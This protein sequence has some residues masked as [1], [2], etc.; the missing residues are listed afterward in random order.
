[1]GCQYA[2]VLSM[3]STE[4]ELPKPAWAALDEPTAFKMAPGTIGHGLL[5]EYH[6]LLAGRLRPVTIF[7]QRPLS[8]RSQGLWKEAEKRGLLTA[9]EVLC[10]PEDELIPPTFSDHFVKGLRGYIE[11][12]TIPPH[13]QLVNAVF[14]QEH[15]FTP[16]PPA[17]EQEFI[18]TVEDQLDT[19]GPRRRDVLVYRYGLADGII[20]SLRQTAI[21]PAFNLTPERIR[22]IEAAALSRLRHPLR[23]RHLKM[24]MPFPEGSL[25]RAVFGPRLRRYL[26]PM[27]DVQLPESI[28]AELLRYEVSVGL[29]PAGLNREATPFQLENIHHIAVW[30]DHGLYDSPTQTPTSDTT[31]QKTEQ[32]QWTNNL[33]PELPITNTRLTA[34]G[35]INLAEVGFPSEIVNKFARHYR[36]NKRTFGDVLGMTPLE[37]AGIRM[38]GEMRAF[39]FGMKLGE[40]L[41]LPADQYPSDYVAKLLENI[42]RNLK[43]PAVKARQ[44]A[45]KA[46]Y[47]W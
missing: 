33:L 16:F 13:A 44:E 10:L 22:Q 17:V 30:L 28:A 47:G 25:G 41:Q 2:I 20:R 3:A 42:V 34:I 26:P 37:F 5:S 39:Q 31:G 11:E 40:L 35:R 36:D 21:H 15:Y 38:L 19:L 14:G 32:K 27:D 8:L 6:Y 4:Q 29:L 24:F 23:A 45:L 7:D 43:A 46:K 18:Q 9:G 12:L 1:M